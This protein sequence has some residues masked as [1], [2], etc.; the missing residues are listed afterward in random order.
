MSGNRLP[1]I[2]GLKVFEAV[3]R[4]MSF[5]LAAD[6]LC[7]TAPAVSHQ[8]KALEK[9][10][11]LPLFVRLNRAVELTTEGREY[12]HEVQ[13]ALTRLNHAT[14]SLLRKKQK[15]LF[16]INTLPNISSLLLV[17]YIHTFQDRQPAYNI[18]VQSQSSR[19]NFNTDKVDVAIRHKLGDEPDL[20]YIQLA[21]IDLTPICSREYADKHNLYH[22]DD[23]TDL[24][25]IRLTPDQANWDHWLQTFG[26]PT[27]HS[28]ELFLNSFQAVL[29]A[30]RSHAGIAMGYKPVINKAVKRGE[31][32]TPFPDKI[33]RY[34][35]VFL[36]F[37]KQDLDSPI[38]NDFEHWLKDVI[39]TEWHA[40]S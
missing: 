28:N 23:L 38:V 15:P 8:I 18:Q 7:I 29:E 6:E 32:V 26:L 17:P 24:R 36:T 25:L 40:A 20:I 10:L 35:E 3:A 14:E 4:H 33:A 22:R 30:T 39:K 13:A 34:G 9:E 37:R 12:F 5:K 31:L 16:V 21:N 2:N 11:G 1:S 19:V 27:I